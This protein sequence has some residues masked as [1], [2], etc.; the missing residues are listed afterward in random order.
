ME[1]GASSQPVIG[2][3]GY[4]EYKK[5]I[6]GESYAELGVSSQPVIGADGYTEYKKNT[7]GE[8]YAELGVSSQPVI[9]ADGYT[10]YKKNTGETYAELGNI[11]T[12]GM[13]MDDETYEDVMNKVEDQQYT[14]PRDNESV[15]DNESGQIKHTYLNPSE[16]DLEAK[17]GALYSTIPENEIQGNKEINIEGNKEALY[18]TI[19]ENKI[20][21]NKDG[22]YAYAYSDVPNRNVIDTASDAGQTE[23]TERE[24]VNDNV[25]RK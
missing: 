25:K 12:V 4:T 1:L 11:N 19:P 10:K 5:N 21:G 23:N 22:E 2:A 18:S 24:Y 13:N 14:V 9:G 15:F 17:R 3:D 20:E 16:I 6:E 8:S 7:E